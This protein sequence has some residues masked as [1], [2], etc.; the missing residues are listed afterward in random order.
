M[1]QE[2]FRIDL[3]LKRC[4]ANRKR[5]LSALPNVSPYYTTLNFLALQGAPYIYD[6]GR[7][8]VNLFN[9]SFTDWVQNVLRYGIFSNICRW[10]K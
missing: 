6:I 5:R 8:R 10:Y 4:A 7:L 1:T 2:N 9:P 3:M